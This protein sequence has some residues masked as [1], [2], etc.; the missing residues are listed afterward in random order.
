M[1]R[2]E[3]I[4]PE[5]L[6][7]AGTRQDEGVGILLLNACFLL[8]CCSLSP[9][10]FSHPTLQAGSHWNGGKEK[11]LIEDGGGGLRVVPNKQSPA[12]TAKIPKDR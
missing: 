1:E 6:N 7:Q 8:F 2:R 10:S 5:H 11:D 3:L 9:F 4:G 12:P